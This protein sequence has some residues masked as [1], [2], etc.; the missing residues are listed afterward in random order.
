MWQLWKCKFQNEEGVNDLIKMPWF[1]CISFYSL[2]YSTLFR[3]KRPKIRN[4]GHEWR[5]HAWPQMM[6]A[7]LGP[8]CRHLCSHVSLSFANLGVNFQLLGCQSLNLAIKLIAGY[9][10]Q[11]VEVRGVKKHLILS[12]RIPLTTTVFNGSMEDNNPSDEVPSTLQ[13]SMVGP[14]LNVLSQKFLWD[15]FRTLP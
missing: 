3:S 9:L 2:L 5:R 11:N 6:A 13:I 7:I 10:Y 14:L 15:W 1:C 4:W 12:D 8:S